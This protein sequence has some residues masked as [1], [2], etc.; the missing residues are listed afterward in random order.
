MRHFALGEKHKAETRGASPCFYYARCG[1]LSVL[2]KQ[3]KTVCRN[4]ADGL[5]AAEFP[6]PE[7][8]RNIF[9]KELPNFW[10]A[11]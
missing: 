1:N 3:G 8:F 6:L 9:G 4:C 11:V 5:V 2:T 7:N 10:V